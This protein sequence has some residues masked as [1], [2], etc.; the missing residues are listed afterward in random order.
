MFRIFS[1]D[2]FHRCCFCEAYFINHY[3]LVCN[4]HLNFVGVQKHMFT[5]FC[6][7]NNLRTDFFLFPIV[8]HLKA[9]R[10]VNK[11]LVLLMIIYCSWTKFNKQEEIYF[12]L[13]KR[14]ENIC[15][16]SYTWT[17]YCVSVLT[18]TGLHLFHL[19]FCTV[20]RSSRKWIKWGWNLSRKEIL[21]IQGE[22][23]K[24]TV[25]YTKL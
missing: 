1:Q 18:Q 13:P 16:I 21:R 20:M 9:L 11:Q 22:L 4:F 2:L 17:K 15:W 6:L 7:H 3:F 8:M 10:K 24:Q 12:N 19:L 25:W 5:L 23:S 14:M